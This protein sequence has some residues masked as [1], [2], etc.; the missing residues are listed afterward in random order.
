[1]NE[2]TVK[3]WIKLGDENFNAGLTLFR[4]NSEFNFMLILQALR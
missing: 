1:M 4:N 3:E 2:K